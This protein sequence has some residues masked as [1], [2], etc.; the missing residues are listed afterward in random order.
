MKMTFE[1]ASTISL[2]RTLLE[3]KLFKVIETDTL[4]ISQSYLIGI[5]TKLCDKLTLTYSLSIVPYRN[6]NQ[7][8]VGYVHRSVALIRTLLELK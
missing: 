8:V 7:V 5:E 4:Y 1:H 2:N 3:L 6:W